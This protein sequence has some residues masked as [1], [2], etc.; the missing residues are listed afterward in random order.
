MPRLTY[1]YSTQLMAQMM[2]DEYVLEHTAPSRTCKSCKRSFRAVRASQLICNC[3]APAP[4]QLPR[5]RPDVEPATQGD[6][7][8]NKST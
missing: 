5:N 2:L 1:R 8:G 4:A 7:H 6:D 3:C